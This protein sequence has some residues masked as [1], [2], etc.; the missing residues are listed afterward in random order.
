MVD[1]STR[2]TGPARRMGPDKVL[3]EELHMRRP[4]QRQRQQVQQHGTKI[5]C[6]LRLGG[7]SFVR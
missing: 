1:T 4:A 3:P 2:R 6:R 5:Y 7:I